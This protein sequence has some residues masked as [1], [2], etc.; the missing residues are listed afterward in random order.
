MPPPHLRD[1]AAARL[2]QSPASEVF[3]RSDTELLHELQVHQIE[4]EMQNEALIES[5]IALE[6]SRDRFVD[7]YELAPVGYL[8]ITDKG[9]IAD[10]NLTGA[11]L[12]GVDR[13]RIL[14][15]R[16]SSF[17][18]PADADRYRSH[19]FGVLKT[20]ETMTCELGLL[21]GLSLIHI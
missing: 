4:L 17:V 6:E 16:F 21:R 5:H 11:A 7:F 8:T 12:L 14:Q 13:N 10:V 1:A 2:T 9:L 18:I 19:F 3:A 15:H 20:D